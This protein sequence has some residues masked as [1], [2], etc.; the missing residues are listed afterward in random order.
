MVRRAGG[1]AERPDLL[2][3]ELEHPL[4][5][6]DGLGLLIKERLVGR[7]AALGHEQQL[8]LVRVAGG[9]LGVQL[10]LRGQIVAGVL[11]VPHGERG[12]L[13][14]AKVQLRVGVVHAPADVLG[15]AP[16]G[17][18]V[19][20][21]LAHD[22]GRTGVLTHRQH[23]TGRDA[24][25]LQQV[26]RHEAVVAAGLG[27][28]DDLAELGEVGRPQ[29]VGDVMDR[30]LGEQAQRLGLNLQELAACRLDYP[31]PL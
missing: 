4:L 12:H 26:E 8:V 24:R 31:H 16:V 21:A 18:H 23:A 3:Q 2:L 28:V 29:V 11:L 30:R 9:V 27:V 6:Q 20:A 1:R 22:D 14:V 5:V 15:V 10:D 7:A 17:Q 25:V 13:G 19:A